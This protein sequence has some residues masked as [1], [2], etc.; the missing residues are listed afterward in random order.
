MVARRTVRTGELRRRAAW[1]RALTR[2]IAGA[3]RPAE[4]GGEAPVTP[5]LALHA[6]G[7]AESENWARTVAG[8]SAGRH[9]RVGYAVIVPEAGSDSPGWPFQSPAVARSDHMVSTP[10]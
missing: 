5:F 10:G 3:D 6:Q 2:T 4:H 8:P 7:T 9:P 1:I